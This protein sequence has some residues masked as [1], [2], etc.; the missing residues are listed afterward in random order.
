MNSLRLWMT[1]VTPSHNLKVKDAMNRYGLWITWPTYGPSPDPPIGTTHYLKGKRESWFSS[2]E[3][4][5][6]VRNGFVWS[7]HLLF[8]FIF[9]WG[10]LK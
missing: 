7:R 8:I 6:P 4:F 9:K 5:V 3:K 1:L 10:K 2:F